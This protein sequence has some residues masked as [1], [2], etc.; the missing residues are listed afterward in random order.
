MW[1]SWLGG[2]WRR[3]SGNFSHVLAVERKKHFLPSDNV[4]AS[5]L[6]PVARGRRDAAL[7][8]RRGSWDEALATGWTS[9][10]EWAAEWQSLLQLTWP[11]QLRVAVA[12]AVA[13]GVGVGVATC[14]GLDCN[15]HRRTCFEEPDRGIGSIRR[16]IG[17]EPEVIQCAPANRVRVLVLRKCFVFQVMESGA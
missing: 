12:V 15:H 10:L 13:V 1:I 11:W 9:G 6:D 7:G 17:I 4:F 16:L 5:P 14:R 2:A 3:L 8:A